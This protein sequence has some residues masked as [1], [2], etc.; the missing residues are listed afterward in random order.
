LSAA[1]HWDRPQADWLPLWRAPFYFFPDYA[2][3]GPDFRRRMGDLVA[4]VIADRPSFAFAVTDAV[5]VDC[6]GARLNIDPVT[7]FTDMTAL[8]D[9]GRR[10][11]TRAFE[12]PCG[13]LPTFLSDLR[14][15]EPLPDFA[16]PLPLLGRLA[17]DLWDRLQT[18]FEEAINNEDAMLVARWGS[19]GA[20]FTPIYPDQWN[21]LRAS[22]QS[23][24]EDDWGRPLTQTLRDGSA[25]IFSP[26][27]R[28]IARAQTAT[29]RAERDCTSWLI[30]QRRA[31]R[32]PGVEKLWEQSRPRWGEKLSRN[33]FERACRL[34]KNA[35][36]SRELD[37]R[38]PKPELISPPK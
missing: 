21:V 12:D 18:T 16:L 25:V 23:D 28:P 11:T 30:E 4:T 31:G 36:R 32:W 22:L 9:E 26:M 33:G 8:A 29:A 3:P 14:E 10:V 7:G 6:L 19:V 27:V 13:D 34:A 38:G 5:T 2:S 17:E 37:K 20:P 1:E 24:G 35:V 15:C